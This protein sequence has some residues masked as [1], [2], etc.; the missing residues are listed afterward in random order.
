MAATHALID[1]GSRAQE[2]RNHDDVECCVLSCQGLADVDAAGGLEDWFDTQPNPELALVL[3]ERSYRQARAIEG[4]SWG[5]AIALYRDAAAYASIAL[6]GPEPI[7]L[8]AQGAHNAALGRLLDLSQKGPISVKFNLE[9]DWLAALHHLGVATIGTTRLLAPDR[10]GCL[11]RACEFHV[12]GLS[13]HYGSEG[14]G[15]PLVALWPPDR[16]RNAR[17]PEDRYFPDDVAT[18]A[19]A[20]LR[21]GG[22]EAGGP[23]HG[24]SLTL[25]L[26]DPFAT[27]AV[28][29]G[30]K[31]WPLAADRTTALA[32]QVNRARGLRLSALTGG[33]ASDLGRFEEGLYILRPYQPGKIPVVLVHGLLSSPLAWAE[34]YNELCNDPTLADH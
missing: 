28:E 14:L 23:W 15:V 21:A 27:R 32:V 6:E 10:I 2:S 7:G 22:P 16:D 12:S 9:T 20:V 3:S 25:T 18:P 29:A 33:I 24:R 34:T 26:Y 11:A 19:T 31:V 17:A 30:G 1:F 5:R 8:R 13:H 4:L